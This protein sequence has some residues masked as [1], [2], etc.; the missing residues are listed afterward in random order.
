MTDSPYWQ[1]HIFFA[2]LLSYPHL[3]G[4]FFFLFFSHFFLPPTL[5]PDFI[6]TTWLSGS[7]DLQIIWQRLVNGVCAH[8]RWYIL[9]IFCFHVS[10]WLPDWWFDLHAFC[11]LRLSVPH[12]PLLL[13]L[14]LTLPSLVRFLSLC[15]A[16]EGRV[17]L[18]I[19]NAHSSLKDAF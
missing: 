4:F 16:D 15:S 19:H 9:Y 18:L 11:L 5:Y 13:Y 1:T 8:S 14:P 17:G 2:A 3:K 10:V 6:A 7:M 12:P